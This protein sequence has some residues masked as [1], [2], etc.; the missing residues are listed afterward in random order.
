[1]QTAG[2]PRAVLNNESL[3]NLDP[4]ENTLVMENSKA[5][6]IENDFEVF[7]SFLRLIHYIR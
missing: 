7:D 6:K 3:V 4:E 1:M 2:F 5:R